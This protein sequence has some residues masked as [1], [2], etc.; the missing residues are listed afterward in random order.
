LESQENRSFR[1]SLRRARRFLRPAS[2]INKWIADYEYACEE[3]EKDEW[4]QEYWEMTDAEQEAYERIPEIAERGI[5]LAP[6]PS[7]AMSGGLLQHVQENR[8]ECD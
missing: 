6:L 3:A 5:R 1:T 7:A 4:M 2:A 8:R